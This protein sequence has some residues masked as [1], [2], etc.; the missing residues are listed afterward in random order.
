MLLSN[1]FRFFAMNSAG[2]RSANTA[3][4]PSLKMAL[5]STILSELRHSESR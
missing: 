3:A 2:D 1:V 4:E 5:I